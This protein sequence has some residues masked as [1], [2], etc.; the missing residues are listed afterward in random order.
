MI[1]GDFNNDDRVDLAIVCTGSNSVD[2]CFGDGNGTFSSEIVL[3]GERKSGLNSVA[4]G[5]FNHDNHLDLVVVYGR[6][7]SIG[8]LLGD[9][10]G[11]FEGEKLYSTGASSNPN[12]IVVNDFN[13]D[14]HSDL[15]YTNLYTNEV[16]IMLGTGNGTF[17]AQMTSLFVFGDVNRDLAVAAGDFNYDGKLDIVIVDSTYQNLYILLNS[18]TCCWSENMDRGLT[19]Y[20]RLVPSYHSASRFL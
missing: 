9:G 19:T 14:N 1:T 8:I 12:H 20:Q 3:N 17:L 10:N 11:N 4:I 16:G 13:N 18:C 6:R 7:D 5:D 15:A 2:V